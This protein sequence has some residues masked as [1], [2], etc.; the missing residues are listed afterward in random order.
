MR[1]PE[2]FGFHGMHPV[3]ATWEWYCQAICRMWCC[4]SRASECV[5]NESIVS[6]STSNHELHEMTRL[7]AERPPLIPIQRDGG[8][9][10]SMTN[11]THAKRRYQTMDVWTLLTLAL[12]CRCLAAVDDTALLQE[13]GFDE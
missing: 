7:P 4:A 1:E 2:R 12:W 6:K 9:Y 8:G 13:Q 10:G 5:A 3:S 11:E